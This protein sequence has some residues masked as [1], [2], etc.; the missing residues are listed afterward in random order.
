VRTKDLLNQRNQKFL[1][2]A[3]KNAEK[4]GERLKGGT[5]GGQN[6]GRVDKLS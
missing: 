6:P 3:K 5:P 2:G 1:R 4:G